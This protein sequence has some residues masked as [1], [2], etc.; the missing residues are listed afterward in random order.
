MLAWSR[1]LVLGL[2]RRLRS[3]APLLMVNPWLSHWHSTATASAL[4]LPSRARIPTFVIW[5]VQVLT[6]LKR[7]RG[8]VGS[9]YLSWTRDSVTQVP[10]AFVSAGST[11][12]GRGWLR[13]AV[14]LMGH[15]REVPGP[16]GGC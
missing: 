2:S 14:D 11:H 3:W 7:R 6:G 4:H 13:T 10:T 9:G 5:C 15:V 16:S 12:F 1:F 8:Y